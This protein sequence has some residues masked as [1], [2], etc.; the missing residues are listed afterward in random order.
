[1]NDGLDEMPSG[2]WD[3]LNDEGNTVP[4]G[5]V[6]NVK[7]PTPKTTAAPAAVDIAVN[8]AGGASSVSEPTDIEAAPPSTA[9]AGNAAGAGP[10]TSAVAESA[11]ATAFVAAAAAATKAAL[12]SHP[13][14]LPANGRVAAQ[15]FRKIWERIDLAHPLAK[16]ERIDLASLNV[17]IPHDDIKDLQKKIKKGT[18]KKQA[19]F[20]MNLSLKSNRDELQ[21]PDEEFWA[22]PPVKSVDLTGQDRIMIRVIDRSTAGEDYTWVR[23]PSTNEMVKT[24]EFS[25]HKMLAHEYVRTG[26]LVDEQGTELGVK[27]IGIQAIDIGV[28]YDHQRTK[29]LK[30]YHRLRENGPK[31]PLWEWVIIRSDDKR[32]RFKCDYQEPVST[33]SVEE[34]PIDGHTIEWVINSWVPPP[35][36]PPGDGGA[37]SREQPRGSGGDGPG[38]ENTRGGKTHRCYR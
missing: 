12:A 9:D 33:F 19:E 13:N 10:C 25:I 34:W 16:W 27:A 8:A 6:V 23:D 26:L 21:G 24:V 14:G 1:M 31:M 11:P 15:R 29:A 37:G 30:K 22:D 28:S 5:D 35:R 38:G 32:F 18:K 7:E 4:E 20:W 17:T 3:N 2:E 36:Y